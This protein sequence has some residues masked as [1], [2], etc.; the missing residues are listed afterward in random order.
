LFSFFGVFSASFFGVFENLFGVFDNFF[1]VLTLFVG[2]LPQCFT[3]VLTFFRGVLLALPGAASEV[4]A[5]L[6]RGDLLDASPSNVKFLRVA[7]IGVR[8]ESG[9]VQMKQA[10]I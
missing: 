5:S 8:P 7:F 6:F 2:V 4:D 10:G 1:G 3:G 9:G